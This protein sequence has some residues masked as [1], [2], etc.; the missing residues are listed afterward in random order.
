MK[1][2]NVKTFLLISFFVLCENEK[3]F[4]KVIHSEF[5]F[6]KNEKALNDFFNYWLHELFL[7]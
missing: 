1:F 3:I 6:L 4:S 7:C 5:I 2:L